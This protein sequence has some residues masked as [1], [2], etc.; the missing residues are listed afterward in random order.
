MTRTQREDTR[1]GLKGPRLVKPK[2][3]RAS[4]KPCC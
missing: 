2:T 3:G 4:E 1:A